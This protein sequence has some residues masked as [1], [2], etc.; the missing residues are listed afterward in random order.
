MLTK[1]VVTLLVMVISFFIF[2]RGNAAPTS[3][4]QVTTQS[5]GQLM[6]RRYIFTAV[7]ILFLL[8]GLTAFGW[9]WYDNNKVVQVSIINP[10]TDVAEVYQVR[11]KDILAD[12]ITTIDGIQIR[13]SSEERIMIAK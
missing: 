8:I 9:N 10:I 3:T 2:K 12:Q 7:M 6:L 5:L 13:L 11:K 4:K 1:I